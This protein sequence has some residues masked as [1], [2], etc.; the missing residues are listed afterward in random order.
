MTVISLPRLLRPDAHRSRPQPPARSPKPTE[1]LGRTVAA[2][3][4]TVGVWIDRYVQR[5]KLQTLS[6][7]ALADL[8]LSRCDVEGEVRKAFWRP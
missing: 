2:L 4:A 7:A 1:L 3:E 8:G 5:Q 6:D